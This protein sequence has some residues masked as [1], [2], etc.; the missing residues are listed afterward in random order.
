[1]NEKKVEVVPEDIEIGAVEAL[2]QSETTIEASEVALDAAVDL[3]IKRHQ[4]G[5]GG[6][7]SDIWFA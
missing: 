3:A 5:T 7:A 6:S 2:E 4:P 1:M